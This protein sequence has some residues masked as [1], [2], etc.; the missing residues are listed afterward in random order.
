MLSIASGGDNIIALLLDNPAHVVAVDASQA[1]IAVCALKLYAIKYLRYE[2]VQHLLGYGG[3]LQTDGASRLDIYA[4]LRPA[5]RDDLKEFWDNHLVDIE[6]GVMHSGMY[7]RF[8]WLFSQL[9]LP[10]AHNSNSVEEMLS[11]KDGESQRR[12]YDDHFNTRIWQM[13]CR[14]YFGIALVGRAPA[15]YNKTR[16]DIGLHFYNR[17]SHALRNVPIKNN[18]YVEYVL[19]GAI[20]G[21]NG[22]PEYLQEKN[23]ETIK[24]RIGRVSL[25][26]LDILDYLENC[27]TDPFSAVNL[28]NI[29]DFMSADMYTRYWDAV[30][31]ASTSKAKICHWNFV[32]VPNYEGSLCI[33][34]RVSTLDKLSAYLHFKER[35][36]FYQ[37]FLVH[38]AP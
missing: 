14:W 19:T 26:Q 24:D 21:R 37:Q 10:L 29:F 22:L 7:D 23:F 4:K 31:S 9:I 38:E 6:E 16:M 3:Q 32:P 25:I 17:L 5:L 30:L 36:Y 8:Y 15:M 18:F 2:E 12:F 35:A 13:V 11:F 27:K 20:S 34:E 33:S 1:Q 28:S